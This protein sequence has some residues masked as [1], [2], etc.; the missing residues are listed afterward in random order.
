MVT[1]YA[2]KDN[3]NNY[4]IVYK[5]FLKCLT[6]RKN[7]VDSFRATEFIIPLSFCLFVFLSNWVVSTLGT[8]IE[9][10]AVWQVFDPESIIYIKPW[11]PLYSCHLKISRLL[12][13]QRKLTLA[14]RIFNILSRPWKELNKFT[15]KNLWISYHLL[16]A[17]WYWICVT[18]ILWLTSSFSH[19][20]C[21]RHDIVSPFY[22]E[23]NW[24]S[25]TS[26][27]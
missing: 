3:G 20:Y 14:H 18:C 6:H 23:E 17:P 5:K 4:C 16:S 27:T 25:G 10:A 22:R 9:V 24:G 2:N 12:I 7:P 1:S 13:G 19:S 21:E 15:Y 8:R 11:F 26:R